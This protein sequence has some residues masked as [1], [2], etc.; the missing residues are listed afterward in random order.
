M[1]DVRRERLRAAGTGAW[2]VLLYIRVS[3]PSPD[4]L[5]ATLFYT[6]LLE[7]KDHVDYSPNFQACVCE[8]ICVHAGM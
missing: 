2:T 1:S 5:R 6:K 7:R 8:I 4:T 3:L